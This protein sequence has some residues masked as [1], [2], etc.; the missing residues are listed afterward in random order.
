MLS[1]KIND[2]PNLPHCDM[3]CDKKLHEKLDKY[4]LT[5]F[6]NNHSTSLL[7]GKPASGKTSLLYS[8]FKADILK[9]VFNRIYLFQPSHSRGSMKD[10]LFDK[11]PDDQKFEELNYD[12]LSNVFN[13][14]K[15]ENKEASCIIF[16]DM[17]AYL[18]DHEN[19][20]MLKE[21]IYNRRHVHLSIYFLCQTYYSVPK[22]IRKLFNN[23][24]IFRVS[25]QELYTIAD[26][27]I[28]QKKELVDDLLKLVYNENYNFL[29]INTN[30]QKLF[31]NFDEILISK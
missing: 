5:K 4:E 15:E 10:K 21:M 20:K 30:S 8:L 9:K 14:I 16:D 7:I 12:N 6:L 29:F 31:K 23:L 19:L 25:K 1:I 18:K 11:L 24:F 2:K 3:L 26:E 22:D 17:T 28:E 27:I 13:R